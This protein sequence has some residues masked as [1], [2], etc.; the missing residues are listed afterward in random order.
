MLGLGSGL[1]YTTTQ[2]SLE[3]NW[4]RIHYNSSQGTD[5]FQ[6]IRM[7]N[8]SNNGYPGDYLLSI[9]DTIRVTAQL[10]L[11]PT[12]HSGG[13]GWNGT[14]EVRLPFYFGG[15]NTVLQVPQSTI[16]DVDITHTVS[17]T[18]TI[19]KQYLYIPTS[20]ELGD[21]PLEGARLYIRNLSV[22][23]VDA[24]GTGD[25]IL[26]HQMDFTAGGSINGIGGSAFTC[27]SCVGFGFSQ[28]L[29]T[30]PPL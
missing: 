23:T 3:L 16:Y 2:D 26:N 29:G 24:N 30:T 4:L 18:S 11:D 6:A 5:S 1:E 15:P 9:G 27:Y 22:H 10:Y 28:T 12:Q 21:R 25:T 14:D 20:T 17:T 8:F 19:V 13:D 7:I